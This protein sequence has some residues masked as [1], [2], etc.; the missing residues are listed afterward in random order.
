MAYSVDLR[1]W[2][3]NAIERGMERLEAVRTFVV[4]EGSIKRWQ[5]LRR[6]GTSLQARRPGGQHPTIKLGDDAVVRRLVEAT[7]D[8]T[9]QEY[10]DQWNEL[11]DKPLLRW[12]LGR[13]IRHLK[14][15]QKKEFEGKGTLALRAS[16][17]WGSA[18]RI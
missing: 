12:T 16:V 8:A 1:E 18:S 4:I 10:T 3:L 14:L 7:P 9:L 2:V 5:K 11:H 15:T 17:V 13:A 6:E